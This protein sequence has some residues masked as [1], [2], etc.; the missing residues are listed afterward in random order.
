MSAPRFTFLVFLFFFTVLLGAPEAASRVLSSSDLLLPY[1]EV[2]LAGGPS[3]TLFAL[4]N[5]S[6]EP[7][8]LAAT[9][10][11]NWGIAVLTVPLRLDAGQVR[12][13]NLRDWIVSG[14]LP[15]RT[16]DAG[17]LAH[18]Q[19]AL[20]GRA[21]PR[22]GLYY[23]SPAAPGLAVGS[24][25]FRVAGSPRPDALWGDFLLL[26]GR[27]GS[28]AGQALVSLDPLPGPTGT[29][30]R[31]GV[32]FLSGEGIGAVTELRVWTGRQA[33]PSP[34][35]E[36][37]AASRI[38]ASLEV[39]DEAGRLLGA[40]SL[41]LPPLA[42]MDV[43]GLTGGEP[44]G[45]IDLVT[46]TDSFVM[47][48][49]LGEDSTFDFMLSPVCLPARPAPLGPALRL[50]P[51][52]DGDITRVPP[53]PSVPVGAMMSWSY[54][55]TN[56]GDVPLSDIRVEDD[57]G[58]VAVCPAATLEPGGMM[59]C[60]GAAV[61]QA[62][63]R[64]VVV[65]AVGTPSSGP[66]AVARETA[67]YFGGI[68]EAAAIRIETLIENEE[69]DEQ[70]GVTV[71]TGAPVSVSFQLINDSNASLHDI[72][73]TDPS[74]QEVYCQV[75][76]LGSGQPLLCSRTMTAQAGPHEVVGAARAVTVCGQALTSR[77]SGWYYG[78][79]VFSPK[80]DI[81][82]E[83][84]AQGVDADIGDGPLVLV[85]ET[86]LLSYVV[87]NAGDTNFPVVEVVEE[88]GTK[89]SCP[90]S[91]LAPGQSMTCIRTETAAPGRRQIV[92]TARGKIPAYHPS[93][94][95]VWK[96]DSDPVAYFGALLGL[97][98]EVSVAGEDAD[99]PPGPELPAGSQAAWNFVLTNT[100]NVYLKSVQ[101]TDDQG[102]VFP[103]YLPSFFFPGTSFSCAATGMVAEGQHRHVATAVGTP[104]SPLYAPQE[105]VAPWTRGPLQ[106]TDTTHYVGVPPE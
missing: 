40:R 90:R 85:G 57:Q 93:I 31:H 88:D 89:I 6:G 39:H 18:L 43:A 73:V 46:D 25:T 76:E 45:W 10:H 14:R 30:A 5:G 62:C 94:P 69:A 27:H 66:P 28:S 81:H 36:P 71:K 105:P 23:S 42:S 4:G 32:R 15:E 34:D 70:P 16:L 83:T 101:V 20:T 2:G 11:T 35:P 51:L 79:P 102:L 13:V 92:A 97:S 53:G 80:T 96:T 48:R 65:T 29:C 95:A 74:G 7:V 103:C 84:L 72:S 82:I 41:E 60:E 44:F 22:D 37:P 100:G 8:D 67:W 68:L 61:A 1:F 50:E 49:V 104:F 56:D 86:V 33:V 91:A 64:Q 54:V 78:A 58:L 75:A 52:A 3:S 98:L 77:D 55:V 47:A 99:E 38:A 59:T 26:D 9:L 12:T 17:E 24:V 19:A 21:S 63:Q 87:L 106:A